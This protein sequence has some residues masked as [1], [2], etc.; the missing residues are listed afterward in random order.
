M[1]LVQLPLPGVTD[2]ATGLRNLATQIE[3]G[4]FDDA[5]NLAWVID[6][7][8]NRIEL[9]MLGPSPSPGTEA[10]YLYC[11]AQRALEGYS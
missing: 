7:G 3:D 6:C 2:I 8:D 11:L 5:H 10:H 1:K 4:E 9:G